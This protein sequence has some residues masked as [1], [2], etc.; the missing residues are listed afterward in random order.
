MPA[1]WLLTG[2]HL[3]LAFIGSVDQSSNIAT[4]AREVPL[5]GGRYRFES[6]EHGVSS[7]TAEL[8]VDRDGLVVESPGA[9][10]VQGG[11]DVLQNRI[12]AKLQICQTL[13]FV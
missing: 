2:I 3:G 13:I 5:S 8:P 6:L 10:A 12:R 7:F 11:G 1:S 4:L 9:F